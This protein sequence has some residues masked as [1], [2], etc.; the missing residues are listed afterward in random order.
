MIGPLGE[1]HK[2]FDD[3]EAVKADLRSG[4]INL[5]THALLTLAVMYEGMAERAEK[6]PAFA[7]VSE[8]MRAQAEEARDA[9]QEIID[10]LHS[11]YQKINTEVSKAWDRMKREEEARREELRNEAE[12]GAQ[13]D[14]FNIWTS[15][16][17]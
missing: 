16:G 7:R 9:R 2:A 5:Q 3:L 13:P 15:D 1:I 8:F 12:N 10:G 11:R 6:I 14:L 4:D 17:R